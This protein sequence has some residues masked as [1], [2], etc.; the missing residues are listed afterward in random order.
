[1]LSCRGYLYTVEKTNDEKIL[2]R[3]KNCDCK[4]RCKTNLAMD[5]ILSEPTEHSHAQT[6][7]QLPVIE[8]RNKIKSKA[9]NSEEV[10]NAAG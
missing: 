3:C 5:T 8:L 7:D 2:F 1:M 4:G 9:A 10:T 6:I